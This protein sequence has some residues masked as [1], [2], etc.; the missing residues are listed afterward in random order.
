MDRNI[1]SL[2]LMSAVRKLC[3]DEKLLPTQLLSCTSNNFFT[4]PGRV[5]E[6]GIVNDKVILAPVRMCSCYEIW[7][8]L[9]LAFLLKIELDSFS[10][11]LEWHKL[12][13]YPAAK[14]GVVGRSDRTL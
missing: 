2:R 9:T 1:V 14:E 10:S 4:C 3:C 13:S 11:S 6:A 8:V 12:I 5:V 7:K